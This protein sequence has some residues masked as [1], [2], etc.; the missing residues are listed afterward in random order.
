VKSKYTEKYQEQAAPYLQEG[1]RVLSACIAQPKGR[2]LAMV[3]GGIIDREIG[4]H[5]QGK[6]T[7]AAAEAGL[8]VEGPMAIAVT[9]QRVM[10]F[11]I[12]APILGRG[13]NIKELLSAIPLGAVESWEYKKFGMK[14]KTTI[15][16]GGT[17]VPLEG[18]AGGKDLREAYEQAK[19]AAV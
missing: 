19:T 18:A 5:Q 15:T 1:E 11:K 10:T 7:S 14:E 17:P 6:A 9:N 3:G 4:Q 16:V 12:G 8:L 13:G 2:T